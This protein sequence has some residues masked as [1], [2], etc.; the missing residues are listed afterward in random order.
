[1]IHATLNVNIL[2][3]QHHPYVTTFITLGHKAFYDELTS[4][5]IQSE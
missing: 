1:V 4:N 2:F 3:K 5:T